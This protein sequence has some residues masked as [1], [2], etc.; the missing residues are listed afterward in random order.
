[1]KVQC[2]IAPPAEKYS[3]APLSGSCTLCVA[4]C[5]N[6]KEPSE[7]NDTSDRLLRTVDKLA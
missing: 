4:V 5:F 3:D 7:S 1:M 2:G 6:G